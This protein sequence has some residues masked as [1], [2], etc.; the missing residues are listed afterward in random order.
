MMK[1]QIILIVSLIVCLSS[2]SQTHFKTATPC[3]EELLKKTPGS[4]I[5]FG[6]GFH[7]KVSQQQQKEIQN[8]LDGIHQLTFSIY[9]SPMA[10]NAYWSSHSDDQE[11]ASQLK[12]VHPPNARIDALEINGTPTMHYNYAAE[13]RPFTC[14][15][16][17]NEMVKRY[18]EDGT[19]LAVHVNSLDGFFRHLTLDDCAEAMRIDG[20]PIK[21]MPI[22]H[23]EW[24]GYDVYYPEQ[25]SSLKMVLLH[26]AGV[27]PYIPVPRKQ[28]LDRCIEYLSKFLTPNSEDLKN[29]ELL[30]GKKERD[31][32]EKKLKKLKD[33]VLKHYQD[34]LEATT[35]AGLLNSP[36]IIAVVMADISTTAPIFTEEVAGGKMLVTENPAYL[37]KDMPRYIPQ[38]IVFSWVPYPLNMEPYKAIDENFPIEKLQAMIDK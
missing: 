24:K 14:G 31:E 4:W 16:E 6:T 22:R 25:G 38:F 29:I 28:Y 7:A 13:F 30:T 34:E 5:N 35:S 27:L 3:N 1:K 32:Q 17:P 33:D 10:C 19:D 15:R 18:S 36:A 21:M 37:R 8:R 26:R 12:I 23:D 9:P 11:F 20:R 2:W